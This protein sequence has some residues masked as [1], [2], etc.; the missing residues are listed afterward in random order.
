MQYMPTQLLGQ[1]QKG[2]QHYAQYD[3]RAQCVSRPEACLGRKLGQGPSEAG[4]L[5]LCLK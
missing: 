5:A 3:G 1:D 4:A 2:K